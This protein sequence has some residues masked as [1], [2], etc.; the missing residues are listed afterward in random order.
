MDKVVFDIGDWVKLRRAHTAR[1]DEFVSRPDGFYYKGRLDDGQFHMWHENGNSAIFF[2]V[3]QRD[4][5][6]DIVQRIRG[7]HDNP[8]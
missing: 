2:A 6:F 5:D 1:I 8:C 7:E 3:G 4:P